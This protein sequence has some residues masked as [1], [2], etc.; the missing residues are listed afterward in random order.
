MGEYRVG[1]AR[2]PLEQKAAVAAV[3]LAWARPKRNG[4]YVTYDTYG[5]DNGLWGFVD[6]TH[7]SLVD[8]GW[9]IFDADD[10]L[11]PRLIQYLQEN[12]GDVAS[13]YCGGGYRR[14][15]SVTYEGNPGGGHYFT[16]GGYHVVFAQKGETDRTS[17]VSAKQVTNRV[18]TEVRDA[19]GWGTMKPIDPYRKW[20]TSVMDKDELLY[21]PCAGT[22]PAALAIEQEWGESAN[23]VC[24]DAEQEA[25]DAFET[26]RDMQVTI[27]RTL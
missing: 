21:V 13:T 2:E 14:T 7:E 9:A 6:A 3:D 12:W 24:V 25:K 1:D 18:S 4:V 16:N 15:G 20:I 27:Q 26:R 5:P 22:A 19:V 23:Y 10:W 8:G 11:L 17:S